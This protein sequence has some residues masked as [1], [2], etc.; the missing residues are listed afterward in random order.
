MTILNSKA[1]V[2]LIL[3]EHIATT[4][5]DRYPFFISLYKILHRK[6]MDA[7]HCGVLLK[8]YDIFKMRKLMF[9]KTQNN[10]ALLGNLLK[11]EPK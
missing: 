2:D 6:R 11:L 9:I 10:T 4:L 3:A 8:T 5:T 1:Q 7:Q